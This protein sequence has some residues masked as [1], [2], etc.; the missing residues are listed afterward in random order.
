MEF[1]GTALLLDIEG[2]TSSI[3]FVYD[4]MFPYVR[5]HLTAFLEQRWGELDVQLACDQIA[6]DAGHASVEGWC[7][8]NR[9]DQLEQVEE[10]VNRLMDNDVKATGLKQLQGLI[11]RAGFEGGE[12]QAHV[13]ADVP[14]AL[15]AWQAAHKDIRIYSSGSVQAQ[16]LFFAHTIEGNLLPYFSGHYD[17]TI[18]PKKDASSYQKIADDWQRAAAEILFLSDVPAELEAAATAGC[19]TGLLVRPGNKPVASSH[20]HPILNSFGDVVI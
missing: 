4:I 10:E 15:T 12:M 9:L 8:P 2:T 14:P 17:T 16:L 3:T 5:R 7:G 6:H 11:W 13:Y 19:Q 18:G 1:H 20:G